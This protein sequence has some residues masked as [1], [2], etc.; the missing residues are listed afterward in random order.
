MSV[1]LHMLNLLRNVKILQTLSSYTLH[2][3]SIVLRCC[4]IAADISN[5]LQLSLISTLCLGPCSK[6][7]DFAKID[8]STFHKQQ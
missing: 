7:N 2:L 5:G 8:Q 1:N 6:C 4:D 3:T